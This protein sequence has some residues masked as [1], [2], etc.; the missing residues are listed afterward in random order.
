MFRSWIYWLTN[1]VHSFSS[2]NHFKFKY[3][4]NAFIWYIWI[5]INKLL[6]KF[7]FCLSFL[8]DLNL[9]ARRNNLA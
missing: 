9:Q 2:I 3:A 6:D 4:I 8:F 1:R 7:C 5:K